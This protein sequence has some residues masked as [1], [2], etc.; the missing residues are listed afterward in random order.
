MTYY[1]PH[2][3]LHEVSHREFPLP[4]RNWEWR[5]SWNNLLFAHWRIS[6]SEIRHLVPPELTIQEFDGS[7]WIGVVPFD[8]RGIMMRP[9]PDLPYVSAFPE[10]NVRLYVEYQGVPGVWFL[11]LD[12]GN[13]LAVGAAR[14]LFNL[15]YF[16]ARMKCVGEGERVRYSARRITFGK[17]AQ[18]EGS[19]GPTGEIYSSQRGTLDYFLTERYFLYATNRK[20]DL[21][22][23]AIHHKPWPLQ[24]A[25]M[26][27]ELDTMTKG[28]GIHL[29]GEPEVL[30]FS[31]SVDVVVWGLERV[32]ERFPPVS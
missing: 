5:Q 15:P 32:T 23:A 17:E 1:S 8:M 2:P 12:A 9:L 18:F 28:F 29:S 16:H 6:V 30:H 11:S 22:R 14:V 21:F 4:T 27:I 7:S 10:I 13:I 19:Y 3:S 20:G 24:P 31:R 25:E 26:E